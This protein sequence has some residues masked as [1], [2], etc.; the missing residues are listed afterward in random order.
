MLE[1]QSGASLLRRLL[2]A[3]PALTAR[4]IGHRVRLVE[5]DHPVEIMAEPF[6]DLLD[7]ARLAVAALRAKRR[8]GG[9]QDAFGE[10]DRR[11]LAEARHR[12]HKN[13]RAS[14]RERGGQYV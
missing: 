2:V 13:G 5:D 6:D 3:A 12:R 7:P 10:P 14:C 8:I 4:G 1:P 11:A 9:E